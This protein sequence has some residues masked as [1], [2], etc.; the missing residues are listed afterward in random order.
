MLFC[1]SSCTNSGFLELS[2]LFSFIKRKG[3]NADEFYMPCIC[4]GRKANAPTW[5]FMVGHLKGCLG[6]YRF[7][8]VWLLNFS[9]IWESGNTFIHSERNYFGVG[10][11]FW[12]SILETVFPE[13][14]L[15]KHPIFSLFF[16]IFPPPATSVSCWGASTWGRTSI[17]GHQPTLQG[18]TNKWTHLP[19]LGPRFFKNWFNTWQETV[20]MYSPYSPCNH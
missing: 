4:G 19:P 10:D 7:S 3:P 17:Q 13:F 15:L 9:S 12:A 11:K 14:I 18:P 8:A 16:W 5:A 6:T 2:T 20:T 1:L